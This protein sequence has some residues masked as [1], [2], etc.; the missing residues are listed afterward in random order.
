VVKA[1]AASDRIGR[2][3]AENIVRRARAIVADYQIVIRSENKE[4]YGRGLELPH[5]Y[6]DGATPAECIENTR[7]ALTAA[8]GYLLEQGK[9]YPSPAKHVKRTA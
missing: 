7:D 5:V 2:P 3:F 6:G 8:V 4:W 9:P 1:K